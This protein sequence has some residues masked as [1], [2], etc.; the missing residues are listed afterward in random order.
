MEAYESH[1][2]KQALISSFFNPLSLY[3]LVFFK[4]SYFMLIFS[5]QCLKY[6]IQVYSQYH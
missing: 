2:S 6:F 1:N 5:Y 3:G 4:A